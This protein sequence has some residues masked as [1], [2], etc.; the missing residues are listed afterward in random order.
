MDPSI[1]IQ[2][3]ARLDRLDAGLRVAEG[4]IQEAT[5]RMSST[6]ANAGNK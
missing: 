6:V 2:I 4:K 5:E 3:T 1:E